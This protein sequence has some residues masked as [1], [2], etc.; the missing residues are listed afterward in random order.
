[1]R[2]LQRYW[3]WLGTTLEL[4]VGGRIAFTAVALLG[5]AGVVGDVLTNENGDLVAGVLLVFVGLAL[6]VVVALDAAFRGLRNIARR[7]S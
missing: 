7:S 6:G 4:T 1:M 3:A 5:A 2:E